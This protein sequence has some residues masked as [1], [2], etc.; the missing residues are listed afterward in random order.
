M[1]QRSITAASR[2]TPRQP[3]DGD[4]YRGRSLPLGARVRQ[5]V[6]NHL[7][8]GRGFRGLTNIDSADG[9][10]ADRGDERFAGYLVQLNPDGGR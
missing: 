2:R 1:R 5:R 10:A 7:L 6:T 3:G 4:A 8:P 9:W